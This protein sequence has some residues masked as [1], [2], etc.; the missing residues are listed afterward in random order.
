MIE[1]VKNDKIFDALSILATDVKD[2]GSARL[3]AAIVRKN[4][5]I[6]FGI[7]QRKS[8]PFQAKYCK[9]KD[10]IY[11]HAEISAIS[12]ALKRISIEE[13]KRCSLYVCRVKYTSTYKDKL[14]FGKA[15]PCEGCR[16][17]I[18]DFGIKHVY[19]TNDEL[20]YEKM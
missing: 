20:G 3:A 9:N 6:S 18:I 5:I 4:D 15:C 16:R 11:L 2:F 13:L 12:N 10:A 8:H 19:F 14:I 1:N 17:A 7:N